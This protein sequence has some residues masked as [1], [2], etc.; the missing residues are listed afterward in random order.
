MPVRKGEQYRADATAWSHA[1]PAETNRNFYKS[2]KMKK[3]E[4]AL[5]FDALYESMWKCKRGKMWKASVARYVEHG[6]EETLKLEEQLK[7]GTY[8]PRK[9]HE[10][11]LTYPK[12]RTCS[13]THIRDRVVQRSVNDLI[14]YPEMTKSFIWDNM[15]CQKGKG[16][17][18]ALDR[19]DALLW[20]YYINN[21]NSNA[22]WVLR[23]DVTHYYQNIPHDVAYRCFAAKL[24]P[25]A[26]RHIKA[27]LD[28]QYPGAKGYAPG[29]QMVQI[30]G[31]SLLDPLDH[32]EKEKLGLKVYERYMDD[33]LSVSSSW[34]FLEWCLQ[35]EQEKLAETGLEFHPAKTK[36]YP[37][38]DG[39]EFLGFTF[40]LT[41]TGKV[42]RLI[43]PQNVK[44]E[45][46]KLYRMAQLAKAGKMTKRKF[47]GCYNAWK[48]HAALGDTAKVILRMDAYVKNL[49]L[50]G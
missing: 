35:A 7:S 34:E 19:L 14:L 12:R 30:L 40:K 43:N 50:E 44:H 31:I 24:E 8:K 37:L 47:Y 10:F 5:S 17:A 18:K 27:W 9:P 25:D 32:Y 26:L 6:I 38:K 2:K 16:T 20:R 1:L 15:A 28:C 48:A 11:E 36:I 39:I 45:R 46:R 21:G 3:I 42:I 13:S 49:F 41:D 4:E 33:S 23:R 22:G 29:S